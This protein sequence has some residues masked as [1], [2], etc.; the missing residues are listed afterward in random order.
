LSY[1]E[2][3]VQ[4]NHESVQ[5]DIS[6]VSLKPKMCVHQTRNQVSQLLLYAAKE[7]NVHSWLSTRKQVE[8]IKSENNYVT[9]GFLLKRNDT[10]Q[11]KATTRFKILS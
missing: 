5:G 2:P 10:R 3:Y 7:E 9:K 8:L 6:R 4:R 1:N 11:L